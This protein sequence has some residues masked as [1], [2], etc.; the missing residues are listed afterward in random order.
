MHGNSRVGPSSPYLPPSPYLPAW[1]EIGEAREA[2]I[3]CYLQCE[4][5]GET[6][7]DTKD[8]FAD[9]RS[10]FTP[11]RQKTRNE[12]MLPSPILPRWRDVGNFKSNMIENETL[13]MT[14]PATPPRRKT[15]FG[16]LD[17][18]GIDQPTSPVL[19]QQARFAHLSCFISRY[20]HVL[21]RGNVVFAV[22]RV[23][24]WKRLNRRT[25]ERSRN[26][27]PKRAVRQMELMPR[28]LPVH[29]TRSL[30]NILASQWTKVRRHS[31]F[32]KS[33]DQSY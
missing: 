1:S 25:T 9:S 10:P 27:L 24:G 31:N 12:Q 19:W 32:Q 29:K 18:S 28:P 20:L 3:D 6:E 30:T 22:L 16:Q 5:T 21:L 15:N 33:T 11:P 7:F 14:I 8:N 17:L 26:L 4:E 13:Q 23:A 2:M